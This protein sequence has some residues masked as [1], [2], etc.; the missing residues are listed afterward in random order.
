MKC[1]F[2]GKK[3]R[4][5]DT[6]CPACGKKDP[7]MQMPADYL[8]MKRAA[9]AFGC[10]AALSALAVVLFVAMQSGW[11]LGSSFQWLKPRENNLY[12]KDSY[13]VSDRKADRL[14]HRVVATMGDQQLT[15]GQLQIYYWMQVRE[16]VENYG[17]TSAYLRLD[18]TQDLA[19]QTYTDGTTTWQQFF[20]ESALELWQSNQA[21][22]AMA[23]E[24]GYTLS[25]SQQSYLDGLEANLEAAAV[26]AGFADAQHMISTQMGA[27][28]T[29][30]DYLSYMQVYYT[31]YAYF[32]TLYSQIQP[33]DEQILDYYQQHK[34]EFSQAGITQDGGYYVDVR[35]ILIGVA[36]DTQAGWDA[37]KAEA[38][39]VLG[40]WESG[41]MTESEFIMLAAVHS[42]DT[43]TVTNGGLLKN[44]VKGDMQGA[45]DDW[46]FSADR[47]A[48]EYTLVK[49]D[50][51][52]HLLYFVEAEPIWYAEARNQLTRAEGR[53]LVEEIL[54]RYAVTVD[55]RKIVL[56]QADLTK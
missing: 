22:A 51:G 49:T 31:G 20:L 50:Y 15:N 9:I 29:V 3:I 21:F 38:E 17:D 13:T 43:A 1:R 6:K 16:F 30:E 28:T 45:F 46:C 35:H 12:Y 52:Y 25:S 18:Y 10:I 11:D 56:A 33:T 2:C 24:N 7:Q 53:E 5:T 55:Y 44:L 27:G 4:N 23:E 54:A 8:Q 41:S 32:Q 26:Q 39:S 42:D 14:S 48:G 37:C 40:L 47:Q 19:K 36:S 34:G